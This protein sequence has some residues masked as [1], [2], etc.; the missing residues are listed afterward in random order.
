MFILGSNLKYERKSLQKSHQRGSLP[1][2]VKSPLQL[3]SSEVIQPQPEYFQRQEAHYQSRQFPNL[4]INLSN[5]FGI[6]PGTKC[7]AIV[8]IFLKLF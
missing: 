1:F 3:I 8:E 6:V 7:Y 2:N 5:I 4:F